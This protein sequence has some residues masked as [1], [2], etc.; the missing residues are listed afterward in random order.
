MTS[1]GDPGQCACSPGYYDSLFGAN[2]TV[3]VCVTCP[4][5]GACTSGYVGA[6]AGYWRENARSAVL[7]QCRVGNCIDETVFGPLNRL[8]SNSTALGAPPLLQ[9]AGNTSLTSNCVE[10]N[11]GPLCGL[12]LPGYARQSGACQPCDAG[13]AW[14]NWSPARKGP[15]L[16]FTL[17]FALV[18]IPIIFCM[19]LVPPLEA[20]VHA[21]AAG[22][23]AAA[24]GAKERT[25]VCLSHFSKASPD[26][27]SADAD[28]NADDADADGT[29]SAGADVDADATTAG[30][31]AGSDD[32]GIGHQIDSYGKL[33]RLI[34]SLQGASKILVNFYQSALLQGA[35]DAHVRTTN[36][37]F[38][39]AM[40]PR[41]PPA[42]PADAP[43]SC[44]HFL[45]VA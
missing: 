43:R 7:Y 16:F 10:G 26:G 14:E 15:L 19:A 1:P 32:N 5:G 37:V 38:A 31:I 2:L 6:A 29:A 45:Q 22:L 9:L 3:P 33:E 44:V 18:C 27:D 8:Q 11:T 13:S 4:P 12:C 40:G 30:D 24:V 17:A 35:A 28:S 36:A 23:R 39:D 25:Q 34:G 21:A 42:A 20:G 41:D